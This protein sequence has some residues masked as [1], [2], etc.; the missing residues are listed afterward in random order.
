MTKPVDKGCVPHYLF[1][2]EEFDVSQPCEPGRCPK[3]RFSDNP[4][5]RCR[6]GFQQL[7]PHDSPG[8]GLRHP[9][10]S[11]SPLESVLPY[12]QTT[13]PDRYFF[14]RETDIFSTQAVC[15]TDRSG[16]F[17]FFG[18]SLCHGVDGAGYC[19]SRNTCPLCS[20]GMFSQYLYGVYPVQCSRGALAKTPLLRRPYLI[21]M[22][23]RRGL[24]AR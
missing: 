22:K 21:F 14:F 24:H 9:R 23:T 2:Y 5:R 10:F 20:N 13:Y 16:F 11:Q 8:G 19:C 18:P 15:R 7:D 4:V 6:S 3:Y 12:F 17:R 1:S